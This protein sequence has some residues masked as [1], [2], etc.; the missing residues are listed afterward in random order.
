MFNQKPVT[1]MPKKCKSF[2]EPNMQGCMTL[3]RISTQCQETC[4]PITFTLDC[5]ENSTYSKRFVLSCAVATFQTFSIPPTDT[6]AEMVATR[7][8][9][10]MMTVWKVSVQTTAFRPPC[11][12]KKRVGYLA[13]QERL[14]VFLH[15][16][17]SRKSVLT[18]QLYYTYSY[19]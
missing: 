1:T 3:A 16:K 19:L 13:T 18:T 5:K 12:Q 4:L 11:M 6:M 10:M 9:K 17:L 8:P 15:I 14:L 7:T 2:S